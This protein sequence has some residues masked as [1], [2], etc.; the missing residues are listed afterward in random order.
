[1]RATDRSVL[2]RHADEIAVP[3]DQAALAHGMK[4][5]EAQFEIQRQQVK[6]LQLDS[7]P[8]IRDVLN[9]AGENAALFIEEQQR[10]FRNRRPRNGS[11]FGFHL[12]YQYSGL[13]R[14]ETGYPI[15]PA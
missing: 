6:A 14:Q 7:S 13:S 11:A 15:A 5:V 3:P 1:M 12:L 9:A 4:F 10:V 8:G 2:K